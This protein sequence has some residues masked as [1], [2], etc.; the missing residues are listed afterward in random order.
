MGIDKGKQPLSLDSLLELNSVWR[1][2]H[3][4]I[5]W[6]PDSERI[7]YIISWPPGQ[8]LDPMGVFG[9]PNLF[10]TP[11]DPTSYWFADLLTA[12]PDLD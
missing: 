4:R 5:S 1:R 10:Y 8:R 7:V 12:Q 6:F 9:P 3:S 2:R 11:L